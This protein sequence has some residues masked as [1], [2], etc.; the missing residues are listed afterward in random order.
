MNTSK[1]KSIKEVKNDSLLYDIGVKKTACFF[2]NG[3]LV[4]NSSFTAY[5][6]NGIFG[7]SGRNID[8][9]RP[10]EGTPLDKMN[11]YWKAAIKYNIEEKMRNMQF[12]YNLKNFALQGELIGEGIQKNL[13][14]LKGQE[15]CF[16]DLFL[17]DEQEYLDYLTFLKLMRENGLQTVPILN[18]NYTLPERYLDLLEE[19]DKTKTAFGNNSNQLIEGFVYVAIEKEAKDTG[20]TRAPFNRLSF[21]A[22][23]REYS[24]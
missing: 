13:Y 10:P 2:A 22:K 1:I 19:A 9:K 14:K 11:V 18:E 4:H 7:V 3:I 6:K 12:M 20:I 17:I 21:K 5:I 8:Y 16:F 24:T 23:S 15:I